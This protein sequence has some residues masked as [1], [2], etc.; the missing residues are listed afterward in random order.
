MK[1]NLIAS[2]LFACAVNYTAAIALLGLAVAQAQGSGSPCSGTPCEIPNLFDPDLADLKSANNTALDNFTK[3]A[4]DRTKDGNK[5]MDRDCYPKPITVAAFTKPLPDDP[6]LQ[7][8]IL[9]S[10]MDAL[11]GWFKAKGLNPDEDIEQIKSLGEDKVEGTYNDTDRDPPVLKTNSTPPKGTKV[12]AGDQI[13]VHATASERHADGHK[14][15][16][17]GVKSFQLIANGTLVDSKD[18]GM[19]PP[20]C[21]VR[22]YEPSYTVPSKPPPTVHLRI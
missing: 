6:K 10:R 16:P 12:K 22:V 7:N 18:Y 8:L 20:P 1:H 9:D 5:D 13:K 14:S 17:S 11:K 3:G 4:L 21:E 2:S 15:W 19:K